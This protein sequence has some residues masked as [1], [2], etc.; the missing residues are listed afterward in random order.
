M[1]VPMLIQTPFPSKNSRVLQLPG[2][3]FT[4]SFA[5]YSG[6]ITV[7]ENSGKN[8]FYWVF[9][10]V[11][12][13]AS[14][15]L[16]LWLNGVANVIFLDSPVGVGFSYSNTLSD[17]QNNGDKSTDG[18]GDTDAVIL[19]TSTRYSIR[20]LKLPTMGPWRAW[21]EDGQVRGWTQEYKGLTFVTVQGGGHEVALHKPKQALTLFKSFLSRTSLPTLK[22]FNDS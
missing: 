17:Y 11:E 3:N 19:V 4:V 14:K 9:E 13:A 12:D 7:D 22:P 16:I 2:Q 6:Y 15:P 20:V 21:S 18:S 5:H 10:A 1:Q 8:L